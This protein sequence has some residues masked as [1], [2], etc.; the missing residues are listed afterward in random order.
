MKHGHFRDL[1][2]CHDLRR[3]SGARP[4]RGSISRLNC[5]LA[6][7]GWTGQSHPKRGPVV[8]RVRRFNRAGMALG[9]QPGR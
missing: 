2:V 1:V 7:L 9:W 4:S 3:V 6:P 5:R 8:G